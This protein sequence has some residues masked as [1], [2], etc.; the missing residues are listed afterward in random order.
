[1]HA[2]DA[3]Q[4]VL[5]E[6]DLP[7][8]GI[9]IYLYLYRYKFT[10]YIYIDIYIKIIIRIGGSKILLTSDKLPSH[11]W[12]FA[13]EEER[14]SCGD[15]FQA[16]A[17]TNYHLQARGTQRNEKEKKMKRW[18]PVHRWNLFKHHLGFR[19]TSDDLWEKERTP[20]PAMPSK[21]FNW[22][23]E[24]GHNYAQLFSRRTVA[25][26]GGPRTAPPRSTSWRGP[27]SSGRG[28]EARFWRVHLCALAPP[29][30]LEDHP[31]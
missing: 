3:F 26:T 15:A 30:Y 18:L 16:F 28:R 10:Y 22:Q 8:S 19:A 24:K 5:V 14:P 29:L 11:F 6:S 23:G 31:T 2:C 25:R 7:A 17:L 21:L 27:S 13:G 20:I 1:M 12:W 9:Y 4:A